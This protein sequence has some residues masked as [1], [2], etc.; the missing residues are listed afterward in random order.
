MRISPAFSPLCAILPS[1]RHSAL[2]AG[3]VPLGLNPGLLED[4]A[5]TETALQYD[6]DRRRAVLAN[7][8]DRLAQAIRVLQ[9]LYA[10]R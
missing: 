9:S 1:D 8:R 3:F 5:R 6:R 4:I 10:R 7:R 2:G